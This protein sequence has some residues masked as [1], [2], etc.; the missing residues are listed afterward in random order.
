MVEYLQGLSPNAAIVDG[1][2]RLVLI[3]CLPRFFNSWHEAQISVGP[4]Q[5]LPPLE[6]DHH[7]GDYVPN[8]LQKLRG[9]FNVPQNLNGHGF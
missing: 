3:F 6:N 2:V 4:Q 8:S 7:T 9:F 5:S 1:I